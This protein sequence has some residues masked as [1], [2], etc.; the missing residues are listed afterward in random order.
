MKLTT[1]DFYNQYI[2]ISDETASGN[3]RIKV[4]TRESLNEVSGSSLNECTHET[5]ISISQSELPMF[6]EVLKSMAKEGS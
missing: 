4:N 1:R 6:I 2:E 3:V 5:D